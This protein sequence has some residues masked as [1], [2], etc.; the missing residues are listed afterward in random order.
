MSTVNERSRS[1]TPVRARMQLARE[2]ALLDAATTLLSEK[3]FMAMSMDDLAARASVS[4]ATLYQHFP[5]KEDLARRV[6][7]RTVTRTIELIR[8]TD[9]D[10]SPLDRLEMC[11]RTILRNR[12]AIARAAGDALVGLQTIVQGSPE[13]RALFE[14]LIELLTEMVDA[15]KAKGQVDASLPSRVLAQVPVSLIRD[16]EYP[17]MVED[18]VCSVDELTDAIA[19]IALRGMRPREERHHA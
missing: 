16:M 9:P 3:G 11:I 5:S 4:K 7:L 12:L 6:V 15:A 18:G 19:A 13:Y 17:R 2:E 1:A 14:E 10:R 8:R